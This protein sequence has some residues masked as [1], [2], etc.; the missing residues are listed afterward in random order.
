MKSHNSHQFLSEEEVK[1][2]VQAIENAE[3]MTSGEIRVHI[4][5]EQSDN[6]IEKAE[7][8]FNRLE[9][10]NTEK[11]NGILFY[12]NTV[13]HSFA[14]IGDEGIHR[15]VGDNFWVST[16]DCVLEE[17]S[18]GNYKT[19]LVKGITSA[20]EQLKHYFP[21][22]KDDKNELPNEISGI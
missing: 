18:I 1:E 15:F 12:V 19:G 6:P 20:G 4:D 3:A 5:N 9:M 2:I 21:Y 10:Y 13:S 16:K 17:F 11:R 14:V 8:H 7:E 22:Q